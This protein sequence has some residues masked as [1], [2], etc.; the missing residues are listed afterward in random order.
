MTIETDDPR[1]LE[2][3]G[4]G[5]IQRL[6]NDR[7]VIG[8]AFHWDDGDLVRMPDGVVVEVGEFHWPQPAT[9]WPRLGYR[10]VGGQ[11]V[12]GLRVAVVVGS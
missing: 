12:D 5:H 6:A 11:L 2:W 8:P 7:F 1:I 3:P 10:K 4:R 9:I